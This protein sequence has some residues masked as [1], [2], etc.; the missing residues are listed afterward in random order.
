MADKL[1]VFKDLHLAGCDDDTA[2]TKKKSTGR[3]VGVT[4]NSNLGPT[5]RFYHD[6]RTGRWLS[7]F[8]ASYHP[9]LDIFCVGSMHKPRC[10]EVFDNS[11]SKCI[12]LVKSVTGDRLTAVNSRCCFHPRTDQIIIA[13]GNSSGRV[14]IVR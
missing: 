11:T 1:E 5:T 2:S 3:G 13:G 12:S 7:T 9:S 6:N 14:T 10:I 8:M 4:S